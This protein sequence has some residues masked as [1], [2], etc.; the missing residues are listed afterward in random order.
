MWNI[1]PVLM[2]SL[3]L[4]S[5]SADANSTVEKICYDEIG[6]LSIRSPWDGLWGC[7][8]QPPS[9]M[10]VHFYHR[11]RNHPDRTEVNSEEMLLSGDDY[12][13][14]WAAETRRG[15]TVI[16]HGFAS[17]SAA[18]WIADLEEA[19]FTMDD[20]D[21]FTVDWS[22]G[23]AGPNYF[24]A[25]ANTR[26][27]AVLVARFLRKLIERKWCSTSSL[28]LIGQSLGAHLASYVAT[29]LTNVAEITGLDPAQP[30]FENN[31]LETHLDPLDAR[32][33][34]VLHTNVLPF[35]PSFGLGISKP[36]GD[37]DFYINGGTVQPGCAKEDR[38]LSYLSNKISGILDWLACSHHKAQE[39][40]IDSIYRPFSCKYTGVPWE[41]SEKDPP[42][43]MGQDC[44]VDSCQQMGLL[45][46]FLPARGSFYIST[47]HTV[48]ICL[49]ED[50]SNQG[51]VEWLESFT[52]ILLEQ[53]T[54]LGTR[55]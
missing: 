23:A 47:N 54:N 27:V 51:V 44:S 36:T 52:S 37:V 12:V 41:P 14:R 30:W 29:N 11:S 8:P 49:K 42:A 46:R 22:Q 18:S 17:S 40:Y 33:V 48:P 13:R 2:A 9:Y 6:C 20:L 1:L 28:H 10:G 38:L 21:V 7:V 24:Q 5:S 35:W 4:P 50:S 31:A 16:F 15:C 26:V 39:Y 55:R 45:S 19:L 34:Q 43:N 32:F 53:L 3:V 25:V